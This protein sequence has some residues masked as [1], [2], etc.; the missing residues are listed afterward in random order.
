[1][2]VFFRYLFSFFS[3]FTRVFSF[4]KVPV[5]MPRA[6]EEKTK[7]KH[8]HIHVYPVCDFCF[9]AFGFDFF[10]QNSRLHFLLLLLLFFFK[11]WF[12]FFTLVFF[13]T[14]RNRKNGLSWLKAVH[15][16]CSWSLLSWNLLLVSSLLCSALLYSSLH[17]SA[18]L[19]S[20]SPSQSQLV[21]A[22][23]DS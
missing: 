19:F 11:Q 4:S 21:S 10:F 8:P 18:P 9:F 3:F 7:K 1:M 15:D 2:V 13:G 6:K 22:P 23:L 17:M 14:L 20:V 5:M 12:C 16:S